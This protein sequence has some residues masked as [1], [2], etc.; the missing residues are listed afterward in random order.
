MS[1]LIRPVPSRNNLALIDPVDGISFHQN[2]WLKKAGTKRWT[3]EKVA[4]TNPWLTIK[5]TDS[6]ENVNTLEI[7]NRTFT[8]VQ[9]TCGQFVSDESNF[10]LHVA[11]FHNFCKNRSVFS[12]YRNDD[13]RQFFA[14][15]DRALL[16]LPENLTDTAIC[17]FVFM[18]RLLVLM[19]HMVILR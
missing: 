6:R 4:T 15:I 7:F 1:I 14:D 9:C 11:A 10:C 19:L 2:E 18:I 8:K 3:I 17:I 5:L 16:R 12:E 13:F